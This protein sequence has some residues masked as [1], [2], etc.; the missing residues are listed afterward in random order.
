V[1]R[2]RRIPGIFVVALLVAVPA[3]A[4]KPECAKGGA[5]A[6][7]AMNCPDQ[8]AWQKFVEVTTPAAGGKAAFLTYSSDADT[9]QCPPA[10][11]ATCRANPSAAG[12]PQWPSGT[13][14]PKPS[15]L[16]QR[17]ARLLSGHRTAVKIPEDDCWNYY[18]N[19]NIEIVYRNR[20]TFDYIVAHG[21]WYVEG[22]ETQFEKGFVYDFPVDSV[23]VKTNWLPLSDAQVAAG[24]FYTQTMQNPATGKNQTYGLAAMHISSKDLP[25]WFW[26]TFEHVDNW[27]RC[28]FLGCHDSFG[29]IPPNIPS[30][31]PQ[32]CQTYAPG[33]LTPALQ[34]MLAKLPPVFQNYRLK[35]SMTDFTSPTG[36]PNLLGNSITEAGFVPTA[37][38]IT[39]HSRAAVQAT[40]SGNPGTLGANG[41]SPYQN[42]AGFTPENQSYNGTPDPSWYY[43]GN[44]P[45]RRYAVQ[46]DFVWAIPFKASSTSATAK[47]C[48]ANGGICQTL[49]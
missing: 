35:G 13:A 7:F 25:N 30:H 33:E 4:D 47:C 17:S 3:F 14:A 38:C 15:L 23:E 41:L 6:N 11:M 1:A 43:A 37:S 22:I 49:P 24:R 36:S 18:N 5:I 39:C 42:V 44:H 19:N 48:S 8:F 46:T 12:C 20:A 10:D 16:T 21:L 28:D 40:P 34:A 32:L 9:F 27:G 29:S 45:I 26:S 31:D 2:L